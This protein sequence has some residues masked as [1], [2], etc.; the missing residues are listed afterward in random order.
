MAQGN[1]HIV[2]SGFVQGVGFRFFA[3]RVAKLLGLSGYVRN[4][5]NSKVEIEVEGE[6]GV[7]EDFL[8]EMRRG[9]AVSHV[10]GVDARW[11][12]FSGKFERF[13]IRL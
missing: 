1:L 7:L 10:T 2:V 8:E 12:E 5:P 13:E 9:P 6:K 3:Q 11:S 4:L